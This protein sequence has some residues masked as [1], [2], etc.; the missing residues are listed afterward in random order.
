MMSAQPTPPA[1]AATKGTMPSVSGL[2]AS[3]TRAASAQQ[4]PTNRG[5]ARSSRPRYERI[6]TL[7][8]VTPPA[9]MPAMA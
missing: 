1:S 3:A 9:A 5:S 8:Y 2:A 6:A 4:P 7:R